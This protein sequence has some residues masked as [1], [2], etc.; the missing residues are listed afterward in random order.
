MSCIGRFVICLCLIFDKFDKCEI[1]IIIPEMNTSGKA[2][3]WL[4]CFSIENV[5]LGCFLF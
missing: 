1:L 3:E 4:T 2:M 5:M